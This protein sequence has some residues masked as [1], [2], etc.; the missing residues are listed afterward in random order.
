VRFSAF[1][2]I[3]GVLWT[4]PVAGFTRCHDTDIVVTIAILG[5]QIVIWD[6]VITALLHAAGLMAPLCPSA[7][8]GRLFKYD[9]Y[10]IG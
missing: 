7:I 2:A 4:A 5:Q 1:S 6:M 10:S 3:F 9:L 8:G